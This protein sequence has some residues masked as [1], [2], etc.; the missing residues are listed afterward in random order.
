MQQDY[1]KDEEIIWKDLIARAELALR[2]V[3]ARWRKEKHFPR[4]II[5]WPGE[6]VRDDEG[7]LVEVVFMD[8]PE[9]VEIHKVLRTLTQRVKPYAILYIEPASTCI[10]II[11]ESPHGAR[12]WVMPIRR[13]GDVNVLEKEIATVNQ[14]SL[15]LLWRKESVAN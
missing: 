13:H 1:L 5:A 10:K 6:P 12:C 2:S 3:R 14:E 15:G 11:L 9:K 7:Q 8:V 4:A